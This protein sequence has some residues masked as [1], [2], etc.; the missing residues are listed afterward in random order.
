MEFEKT[1]EEVEEEFKSL[2][3]NEKLEALKE[4]YTFFGEDYQTLLTTEIEKKTYDELRPKVS[5]S[6][7]SSFSNAIISFCDVFVFK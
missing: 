5:S 6:S 2:F 3:G 4:Q 1:L 7:S